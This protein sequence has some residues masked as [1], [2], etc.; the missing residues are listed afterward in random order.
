MYME[1]DEFEMAKKENAEKRRLCGTI[2][3]RVFDRF[4]KYCDDNGYDRSK[5]LELVLRKFMDVK[6]GK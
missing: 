2:D 1:E 5:L 4:D 6:E 3:A